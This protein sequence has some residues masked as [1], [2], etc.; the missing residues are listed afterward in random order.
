MIGMFHMLWYGGY[1]VMPWFMAFWL[2]SLVFI[3]WSLV[4]I[5]GTKKDTGY[6]L[7]WAAIVVF[8][9]LIGVL[10]YY[11]FEKRERVHT[12]KR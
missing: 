2:V 1:G 9:G 11:L 7:I 3:V 8:L 12:R 6:K 5:A 10:L 4:D